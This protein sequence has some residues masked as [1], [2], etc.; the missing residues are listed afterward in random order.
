MSLIDER[1][2]PA[3][4]EARSL[5]IKQGNARRRERTN[6]ILRVVLT[7]LMAVA[8]VPLFLILFQ[9]IQRGAGVISWEFL[10]TKEFP[11]AR[12][13]GAGGNGRSR[14]SQRRP[15]ETELDVC[16]RHRGDRRH[17]GEAVEDAKRVENEKDAIGGP[18]CRGFRSRLGR[19]GLGGGR[20]H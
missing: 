5:L 11:P 14:I 2:D 12:E 20:H 16:R 18:M 1:V 10:T 17:R 15:D 6:G 9:V 3:S 8:S 4:Q 7:F 19:G 13:G